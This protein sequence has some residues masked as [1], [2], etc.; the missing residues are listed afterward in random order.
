MVI[1]KEKREY[2]IN[3]LKSM[4]EIESCIEPF[5]AQKQELRKEFVERGWLTKDEIWAVVKAH[6]MHCDGK[7][8]NQFNDIFE[9]ID[10]QRS[11][12]T[13]P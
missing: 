4:L 5:K 11:K 1:E 7:D 9:L 2:L 12:G 8:V 13:L 6:R 3:Y 10:E